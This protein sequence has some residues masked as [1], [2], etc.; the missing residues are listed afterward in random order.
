[1][2]DTPSRLPT[3]GKNTHER[4]DA[5]ASNLTKAA[6]GLL[7]LIVGSF[8]AMYFLLKV[9]EGHPPEATSPPSP[10]AMRGVLPPDPRL[11]AKPAVDLESFRAGEDSILTTY[12][13]VDKGSGIVRIPIES[14][15][16]KVAKSGLPFDSTL[17]HTQR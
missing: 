4:S 10:S 2:A 6:G 16:V 3:D 9:F 1:M 8:V 15:I 11:Q 14:A 12:G 13:W 17:A 7:V 5:N